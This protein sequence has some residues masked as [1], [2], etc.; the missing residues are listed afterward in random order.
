MAKTS[1]A[2]E[3]KTQN[4][5]HPYS[6]PLI[7][8]K[9]IHLVFWGH[10]SSNTI[11]EVNTDITLHHLF[12]SNLTQVS[13][14]VYFPMQPESQSLLGVWWRP[15]FWLPGS[16]HGKADGEA[17]L[18]H[19]SQRHRNKPLLSFQTHTGRLLTRLKPSDFLLTLNKAPASLPF[20]ASPS[21]IKSFSSNLPY[22]Q[23]HQRSS[24]RMKVSWG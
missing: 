14:H 16:L 22:P 4:N 18:V 23:S 7:F 13:D 6:Q 24:N 5:P 17:V 11:W 9:I 3:T 10:I 15:C 8:W 2:E 19:G 12:L 21:P 20:W 1:T